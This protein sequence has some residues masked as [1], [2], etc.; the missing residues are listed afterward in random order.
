MCGICG[1]VG[2]GS[3]KTL[4]AMLA[5]ISHRG[6]DDRGSY[7][8]E[9][10]GLGHHRLAI[11]DLK[12]GHQPMKSPTGHV[13]V[14]NGEIYNFQEIR[15][16]LEKLGHVFETRSDT[17][18]ILA[19]YSQWGAECLARFRGMFAFALW[20]ASHETLFIARDRVG[21]K[22]LY[23]AVVD[24]TF[25]FASEAKA[26][27]QVPGFRRQPNLRA[28]GLYLTFR[29]T[30]GEE[31]L[32]LGIKKLLPGHF[33][34]V[35]KKRAPS[36]HRYW[37][38]EFEAD[39]GPN[40][41]QWREQFWETFHEA[42]KLRMI[43]DVPLG[44]YLSGGLDSS[45]IVAAM[46]GL[47]D[48]PVDAFSVG[49]KEARFN[50]LSYAKEVAQLYDCRH[51]ILFAER[52]AGTVL[53]DVTYHLDEPL[54]DLATI[55]TYLM[56]SAT[57][58]YV[59]VVLSGEGADEILAGYPKYPLFLGSR[60]LAP[61]LP[62]KVWSGAGYLMRNISLN[63]V[64]GALAARDPA[65]AYLHLT[66]VF[67]GKEKNELL[68]GRARKSIMP[69]EEVEDFIRDH[70]SRA[71]DG[72]SQ[73]LYLD[74]CTWLPDDLLLKNDKMTMAHA[75]EARVPYL[76]HKVVE[77][78]ARI[79]SRFKLRWNQQKALLRGVM[80]GRLPERIRR[81][82]KQGFTVPLQ[83]W[84]K[85]GFDRWLRQ[86]LSEEFIR[87]QGLFSFQYINNLRSKPLNHPYYRRQIWTIAAFGLWQKQFGVES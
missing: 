69:D 55:P 16:E 22:P 86:I 24:G 66:S 53:E 31:T 14:F 32:F 78:C 23:Y 64:L 52:D 87:R 42:V 67:T 25:Y 29:Y 39:N 72:L 1:Y 17:E 73:L 51:H 56:A 57:K 58:P 4:E 59:S 2:S 84:T 60:M 40:E 28:L 50:E 20:D 43:S 26:L 13:L 85:G 82:R 8:G 83:E 3:S 80:R 48:H 77:L 27:L 61:W 6:P 76:D 74:F 38:V 65:R 37:S 81:R 7:L 30:P 70:F 75:V 15:A 34:V 62:R 12:A 44:A 36:I 71:A 41:A 54:A 10:I 45:L 35:S 18:V 47:A 46:S 49:F 79:P 33:M 68:T 11:I 63:R 19:A 9:D 21:I 5:T